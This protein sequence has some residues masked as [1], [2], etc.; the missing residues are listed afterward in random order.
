MS[1]SAP[2]RCSG[3]AVND[4]TGTSSRRSSNNDDED[5]AEA[6]RCQKSPEV[7]PLDVLA[8]QRTNDR[9]KRGSSSARSPL[10]TK[11]LTGPEN[12]STRLGAR[13]LE[14]SSSLQ[15]SL[16]QRYRLAEDCED[17]D[18]QFQQLEEVNPA[19]QCGDPDG[20][21][22]ADDEE[23]QQQLDGVDGCNDTIG[24]DRKLSAPCEPM[25]RYDE[26]LSVS[27]SHQQFDQKFFTTRQSNRSEARRA[28]PVSPPGV[29]DL[30]DDVVNLCSPIPVREPQKSVQLVAESRGAPEMEWTSDKFDQY[31]DLLDFLK[32]ACA[33]DAP[34]VAIPGARLEQMERLLRSLAPAAPSAEVVDTPVVSASQC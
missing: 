16:A 17:E 12:D 7:H 19:P 27:K 22:T 4:H 26:F 21:E 9:R 18:N 6:L 13:A 15:L 5:V 33:I 20:D 1:L 11:S 14:F 25:V 24:R 3:D 2:R 23:N 8:H 10:L 31:Y 34:H 32:N 28:L 29:R 30:D